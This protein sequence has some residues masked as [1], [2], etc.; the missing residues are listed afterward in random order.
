MLAAA[1]PCQSVPS[2]MHGSAVWGL[3]RSPLPLLET[4][5][6]FN[7]GAFSVPEIARAIDA[8]KQMKAFFIHIRILVS[9]QQARQA[10]MSGSVSAVEIW[11]MSGSVGWGLCGIEVS[12]RKDDCRASDLF[13]P[14]ISTKMSTAARTCGKWT[15]ETF[16]QAY[17]LAQ[18]T[19]WLDRGGNIDDPKAT[20]TNHTLLMLSCIEGHEKMCEEL[21]KRGATLNE[22]ATGGKSALHLAT[23]HENK[24][25]V[26]LLLAAGA[27]ANLRVAEDDTDYTEC[28]GMTALEIIEAKLQNGP[29]PRLADIARMLR[30]AAA[31][32]RQQKA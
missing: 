23:I 32:Q 25:C 18:V 17:H 16:N 20:R 7:F 13:A 29:R 24:R 31:R 2:P 30:E 26:E 9:R 14:S 3:A 12:K 1:Q 15:A 19:S 10:W 6:T 22:L 11:R 27:Q 28:D 5:K 21:I 8:C 4:R